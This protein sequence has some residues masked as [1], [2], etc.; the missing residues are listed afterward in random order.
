MQAH[1][2]NRD[3]EHRRTFVLAF[4]AGDDPVAELASFAE[5]EGLG[6]SRITAIGGFSSVVLG[7]FDRT[8]KAYERIV[9]GQ[10][11][12]V[13]SLIGDVAHDRGKPVAHMHIVV[14]LSDGT[15]RGGHLLEARV[16]PTMEV[17]LTEYPA[18]LEKVFDP[19]VG[20]ALI[21]PR[22]ARSR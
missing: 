8:R 22:R 19:E 3:G 11:V 7:Y 5:R 20:L 6:A 12:E 1:L 16:W 13:L 15:T 14:G 10:Q 2:V 4:D 18:H 21:G 17:V 9:V